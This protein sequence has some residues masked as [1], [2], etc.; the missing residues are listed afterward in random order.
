MN[1]ASSVIPEGLLPVIFSV[2][3][4]CLSAGEFDL[5]RQSNP[6]GFILFARNCENPAQLRTLT[7]ALRDAVG[8]DC[9]ILVD[10]EGGRVQR[11]K[12][13]FW[14]RYPPMRY[15]GEMMDTDP[16]GA[17]EALRFTILQMGEELRA[18]GITTNCAPVLDVLN[19]Q[20]HEAIGDRAFSDNPQS[21]GRLGLSVCRNLLA[22]GITPVIKHLP[23]HGR[24]DLDSHK[25]LPRVSA[26]LA[27]LEETDFQP[28]SM[29]ARSDI[30]KQVWGMA[31]H[32][33]YEDIDPVHAS[34]VSRV[35]IKDIIRD[36]LGFEGILLSD[37]LDMEALAHYGDVPAR[38]RAVLA[39]GCDVALYCG[40]D[41]AVM[42]QIA[43][44]LI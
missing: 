27:A 43:P 29:I 42:R 39:A 34:S 10:Q 1:S 4:S 9:P 3:D 22:M 38:A 8:R 6:L 21:V 24:A 33:V 12:P 20:T 31:A 15:F 40:G 30:G 25:N 17:L 11:L 14:R 23:G 16:E 13:P 28:F 36:R 5:F 7:D 37:D 2:K 18:A 26:P 32:I 19:A 35:I 44:A 41:L